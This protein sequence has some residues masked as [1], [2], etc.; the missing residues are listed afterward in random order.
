MPFYSFMFSRHGVTV[1]EVK[2]NEIVTRAEYWKESGNITL[3]N[4][5]VLQYIAIL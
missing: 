3:I 1:A 4:N 5:T 2:G